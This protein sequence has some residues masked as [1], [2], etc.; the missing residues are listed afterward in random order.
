MV[1]KIARWNTFIFLFSKLVLRFR[2]RFSFINAKSNDNNQDWYPP[3]T[4]QF[5][6]RSLLSESWIENIRINPQLS[7]SIWNQCLSLS[8]E[9]I[10]L[11]SCKKDYQTNF[12]FSDSEPERKQ[13][14]P[15]LSSLFN[16]P[17]HV[18]L[19][20]NRGTQ[21]HRHNTDKKSEICK[22]NAGL[23]LINMLLQYS[24]NLHALCFVKFTFTYV[25]N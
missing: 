4:C 2:F 14:K 10:R 24:Y 25:E 22:I 23:L 8:F 6:S 11:P 21:I 16:F 19:F 3:F 18:K 15:F 5:C 1:C 7:F 13:F 9:K 20:L 12:F 17:L